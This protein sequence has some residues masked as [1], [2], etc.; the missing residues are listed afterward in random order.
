MSGG[1]A[2]QRALAFAARDANDAGDFHVGA[3][4]REAA[5]WIDRWPDWPAPGL[6]LHGPPGC[7]KS[8]LLAIW[9]RRGGARALAAR[10]LAAAVPEILA[11]RVRA[12]AVD[13]A[14]TAAGP[15]E[16]ALLH[17]YNAVA[18][19]R[20]SLLLS[21]SSAPAR[22]PVRLPDLR[23]RVRALP[24]A[25]IAEPDDDL[26]AAVLVK[27]F[28]DRRAVVEPAVVEW[29]VGRIERSF[30]AARRAVALADRAAWEQGRAITI[31]FVRTLPLSEPVSGAAES[32]AR[33][34]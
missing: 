10:D 1:R 17:L 31:P 3:A 21:A 6:V 12:V 25:A 33:G 22:W 14:D 20:G 15:G 19:R 11:G 26:L 24:A 32:L 13:D 27:L 9:A 34:V 2:A 28:A 7:G 4:N 29:L 8:H 16:R 5:A 30:A 23:S 18:A